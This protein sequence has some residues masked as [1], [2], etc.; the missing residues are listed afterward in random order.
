MNKSDYE[1]NKAVPVSDDNYTLEEY[2]SRA[3]QV[4][5]VRNV[6]LVSA[7]VVRDK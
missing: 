4:M 5:A 7:E 1:I 2:V 3:V 6:E